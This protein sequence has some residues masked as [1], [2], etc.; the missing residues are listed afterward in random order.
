MV[1]KELGLLFII[2]LAFIGNFFIRKISKSIE[3]KESDQEID[4]LN[5]RTHMLSNLSMDDILNNWG[6]KNQDFV[7]PKELLPLHSSFLNLFS[8]YKGL[9]FDNLTKIYNRDL[10]L[11]QYIRN[12]NFIQIG[13]WGDGSEILIRCCS[14][15]PQ[16]YIDD[17]EDGDLEN[18]RVLAPSIEKYILFS[19]Q[20]YDA[21]LE[22]L[23]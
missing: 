15:D 11:S 23:K 3:G 21:A 6:T 17:F 14:D 5:D 1:S 13:N 7:L 22:I 18:P 9:K 10:C 12:K 16:V 2:I 4:A 19:K 20:D 8:N